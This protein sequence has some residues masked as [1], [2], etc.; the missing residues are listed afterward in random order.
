M[1][2]PS[3]NLECRMYEAQYPE[4]GAVVMIEVNS[5]DDV[6][7]YVSL[8]EY[9]D[10][11]G[12]IPLSELS[13]RRVRSVSSLV[14]VG[15]VEPNVLLTVDRGKGCID[16]SKCCVSKQDALACEEQYSKSKLVHSIMPRVAE[17]LSIDLE[18]LYVGIGW[19]LYWKY[20]HA[21][22]DAMKE[23]IAAGNDECRVKVRLVASPLYVLA[24][25]APHKEQGLAVLN[26]AIE[27]CA[28]AIERH[29]GKLVVKKAPAAVSV[30][31]NGLFAVAGRM[32]HEL[33]L[34]DKEDS[35]D[36][37]AGEGEGK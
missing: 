15:C 35:V 3:P 20:G 6:R 13:C 31:D 4:A 32:G 16:L 7:V 26:E 19:P 25:Q 11:E 14:R 29:K 1:A 33:G 10:I 8:L 22:K 30:Q 34:N 21:F 12:M 24:T 18:D 9:G 5:T 17:T 36:D 27:A 37:E 23:A 28:E 2:T